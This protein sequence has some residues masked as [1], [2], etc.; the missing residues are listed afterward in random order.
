[1][2]CIYSMI[3]RDW[4]KYSTYLPAVFGRRFPCTGNL[5]ITCKLSWSWPDPAYWRKYI[6]RRTCSIECLYTCR[7]T[8]LSIIMPMSYACIHCEQSQCQSQSCTV[9]AASL[10]STPSHADV[11][12]AILP[13]RVFH[14][15]PSKRSCCR[16]RPVQLK[17]LTHITLLC[18]KH[19]PLHK[20]S[21]ERSNNRP[22]TQGTTYRNKRSDSPFQPTPPPRWTH[23]STAS[24]NIRLPVYTQ[25]TV[26]QDA[27]SQRAT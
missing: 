2:H 10:A 8:P 26:L 13:V 7:N 18:S 9:E 6:L 4:P 27:G 17:S 21:L 16:R 22:T 5:S 20:L 25:K 12:P 14:L 15:D 11:P 3:T 1:M 23:S 19:S 24:Q